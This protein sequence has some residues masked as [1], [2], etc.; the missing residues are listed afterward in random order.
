METREAGGVPTSHSCLHL[1]PACSWAVEDALCWCNLC[2]IPLFS[3]SY[4]SGPWLWVILRPSR[5]RKV[6]TQHGG[7]AQTHTH[8]G[9]F[10]S[11]VQTTVTSFAAEV[12]L[13]TSSRRTYPNQ[14][15]LQVTT[16]VTN[17]N[18]KSGDVA[19][20]AQ[21]TAI[22]S[23]ITFLPSWLKGVNIDSWTHL[24]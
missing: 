23:Y 8:R 12:M 24:F 20:T 6:T 11:Q 7:E 4:W 5:Q 15:Y 16:S 10:L 14:E 18:T 1:W 21:T 17:A 13:A 22:L 3:N 2:D 19:G 9:Q